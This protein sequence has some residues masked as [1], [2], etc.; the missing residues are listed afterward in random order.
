MKKGKYLTVAL[1][2]GIIKDN[3]TILT[4]DKAH[5]LFSNINISF[6]RLVHFSDERKSTKLSSNILNSKLII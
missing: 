1:S 5:L 3:P 4:T 6:Y 2:K